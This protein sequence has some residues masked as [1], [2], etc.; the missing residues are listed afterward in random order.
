M[1]GTEKKM[2]PK[3]S[4]LNWQSYL[5]QSSGKN[6]AGMISQEVGIKPAQQQQHWEIIQISEQK[7]CSYK[8]LSSA[9]IAMV[10][11]NA[12][13]NLNERKKTVLS[14][15]TSVKWRKR[16]QDRKIQ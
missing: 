13:S 9:A 4:A 1:S 2:D 5:S 15:T 7:G 11:F 3:D 14:G 16:Q 12:F 6:Q 8:Y 10:K